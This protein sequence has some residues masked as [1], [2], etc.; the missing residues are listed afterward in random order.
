[1]IGLVS[2]CSLRKTNMITLQKYI[3][4]GIGWA[5]AACSLSAFSLNSLSIIG[6]QSKEYLLLNVIGSLFLIMYGVIKK[7]YASWVLN[8]I[9]LLITGLALVKVYLVL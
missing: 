7:A 3:K 6:S 1:M 5:G 2:L 9:W 4:E 8:G